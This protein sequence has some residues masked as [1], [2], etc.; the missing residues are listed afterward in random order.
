M[1]VNILQHHD[2]AVDQHADTQRQ[3]AKRHDIDIESHD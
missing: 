3:S 1:A 2:G